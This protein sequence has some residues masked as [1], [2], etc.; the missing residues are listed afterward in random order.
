MK[1][2]EHRRH[3]MRIKPFDHLSQQGVD[4]AKRVGQEMGQFDYIVTTTLPRA[5]ETVTA[6][7]FG[8]IE[9][10]QE[11]STMADYILDEIEWDAGFEKFFNA[12]QAG[13]PVSDYCLY[14]KKLFLGFLEK[15]P[16][17]GRLLIVSHGGIVEA[18]VLGCLADSEISKWG[19]PISY[20]E[21]I[22][23]QFEKGTFNTPK[24]LR[25]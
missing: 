4:L 20:C 17:N 9:V 21:G 13:G 14:L 3:A 6:M 12:S 15:T 10:C 18:S 2:L 24:L 19:A 1:Y 25:V 7:G 22:S 23:L 11:L 8:I 5:A 16:E